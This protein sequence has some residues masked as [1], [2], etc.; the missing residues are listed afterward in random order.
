MVIRANHWHLLSS[1]MAKGLSDDL[2]ARYHQAWAQPHAMTCMLNWYRAL[3]GRMMFSNPS[4]D[5]LT[6]PTLIIWGKLDPHLS[7]EMAPMSIDM[8]EK[9]RLVVFE[10]ATHWVHQDKPAEFNQLMLEHFTGE[11][12]S[13]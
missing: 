13:G 2:L 3:V 9:G 4:W 7:Y 5:A 8:C 6:V 10:D 11:N 12:S 1:A